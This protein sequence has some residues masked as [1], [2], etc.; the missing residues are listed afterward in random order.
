MIYRQKFGKR[1]GFPPKDF[2]GAPNGVFDIT[3]GNGCS[4]F[5]PLNMYEIGFKISLPMKMF[6]VI[7]EYRK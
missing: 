1:T 3:A 6:D 5:K 4:E 7:V 2:D